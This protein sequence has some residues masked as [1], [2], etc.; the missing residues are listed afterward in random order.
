MN[1]LFH[2]YALDDI[3]VMTE[4]RLVQK[5]ISGIPDL[6]TTDYVY[7]YSTKANILSSVRYRPV[8]LILFA[9]EYQFFG[10]NPFV[11]HLI[12]LLLFALLIS[13]LY[14]LLKTHLFRDQHAYLAF[15][16]CLLFAIHPVHTEV[17]ANVKSRDELLTFILLIVSLLTFMKF[18]KQSSRGSLL[19]S[20]LCFMLALLTKETAVTFIAV[21]PLTLYFFLNHSLYQSLR[22]SIPFILVF[23]VY[24]AIRYLV[25]G[26]NSYPVNDVT[27]A[28][29]L[30]ATTA[31]AFATKIFIL[32]K[33]VCL[34]LVPLTLTTDYGYNQIPYIRLNSFHFI[35]SFILIAGLVLFA[36]YA[37]KRKS[38]FS[39][40]ILY[41]FAT[42]SVG[43]NLIFDFGTTMAERMLFQPSLAF[44]ILMGLLFIK[45]HYSSKI[46]SA[47]SLLLVLTLF[48]IK[49]IARNNEWKNNETLFLADVISS[50]NSAR[51]NLYACEQYIMKANRENDLLLKKAFLERAIDHGEQSF[52]I[53]S[54]FA[55]TYLRLGLAYYY[56]G[57]Y[58]KTADL[59]LQANRAEPGNPEVQKWTTFLSDLFYKQGNGFS[60][61]DK[62]E[63]AIRF[64]LKSTELNP[65][66]TDAWYHLGAVYLAAND[67]VNG[68]KA[69]EVVKKLDPGHP[70]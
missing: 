60:E 61:H 45:I 38:I 55:Y 8:S 48:S 33:Y 28:P 3:V 15:F 59:W 43:T 65:G 41:F 19:L 32:F 14:Q 27:N 31:E 56:Y 11:S 49:T 18:I 2:E 57:D 10:A 53:Y 26:L 51:I 63:D 9:L 34:L 22:H 58:F 6:L 70:F 4:N 46:S 21:V 25:V 1:T 40:C 16:S 47:I 13:L 5:G 17:I 36:V 69:W 54:K 37:F 66:N 7:G 20:L 50:P 68:L 67:T 39:F 30:Y 52:R 42:I 64:Y 62:K 35:L 24:M 23:L 29:Y 12:N 44:C